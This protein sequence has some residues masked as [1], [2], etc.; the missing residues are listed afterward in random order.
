MMRTLDILSIVALISAASWTF[1]VKHDADLVET[2]IR[3]MERKIAAEKETIAILSADWT[4]LN[5]PGRLQSL[6]ETYADELKLVTVRPDQI[7]AEHQ[8]PAPPEPKAPDT[9]EIGA[10]LVASNDVVGR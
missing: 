8:L 6:S 2:E 4:L 1:H 3:K 7:V 9:D 10:E 5:Q